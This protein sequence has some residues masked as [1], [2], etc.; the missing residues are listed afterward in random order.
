[1]RD[2][3]CKHSPESITLTS[4]LKI[5]VCKKCGKLF[6]YRNKTKLFI[7]TKQLQ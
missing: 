1:M 6:Y 7:A 2:N 4:T 3:G 5:N